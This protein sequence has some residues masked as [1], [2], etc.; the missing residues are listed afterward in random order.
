MESGER[1]G[2]MQK[3]G[4]GNESWRMRWFVLQNDKLHYFK[5]HQQTH[6]ISFISL[7]MGV[8][9]ISLGGGVSLCG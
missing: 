9:F 7:G 1:M 8:S 2:Y 3:K 6:A 4:E 5:S